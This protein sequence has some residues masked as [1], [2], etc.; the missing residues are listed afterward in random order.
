MAKGQL[1]TDDIVIGII[2]DRIREPDC[3]AGFILDGFPRTVE[4]A[5]A[6]DELLRQTGERVNLVLAFNVDEKV[7]E[8]R[9]CGRW[10][11]KGSGRSYHVKF[12]PP[13]SMKF[14]SNGKV[15][16]ATMTDDT[17]GEALYQRKDDTPTALKQRLKLYHENNNALCKYY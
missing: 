10:M 16:P 6:L 7:L 11:H 17:T 9:V 1:V 2:A 15:D 5:D 4:Q 8:E 3:G 14:L 12:A 13:K